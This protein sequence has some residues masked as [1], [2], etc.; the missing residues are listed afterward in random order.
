M[1]NQE[2]PE[3]QEK[4]EEKLRRR[5]RKE[6]YYD[7]MKTYRDGSGPTAVINNVVNHLSHQLMDISTSEKQF[8]TMGASVLINLDP[9]SYDDEFNPS[10]IPFD[11]AQGIINID[12]RLNPLHRETQEKAVS[13]YEKCGNC[14]GPLQMEIVQLRRIDE[15]DNVKYTCTS[16]GKVSIL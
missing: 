15:P 5:L 10:I 7:Y 1:N 2:V 14:G 12:D 8:A 13:R 16:C 3:Y 4:F 9:N 6:P 11:D